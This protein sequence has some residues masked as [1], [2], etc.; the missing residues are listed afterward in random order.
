[1]LENKCSDKFTSAAKNDLWAKIAKTVSDMHGVEIK[2]F[3]ASEKWRSHKGA[4]KLAASSERRQAMRT[5]NVSLVTD[6]KMDEEEAKTYATLKEDMDPIQFSHHSDGG[7]ISSP[8][9]NKKTKYNFSPPIVI[10]SAAVSVPSGADYTRNVRQEFREKE[11]KIR[12]DYMQKEHEMRVKFET[13][14]HDERMKAL[15][16]VCKKCGESLHEIEQ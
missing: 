13:E 2:P 15:K 6:K 8:P 10:P 9:P 11:H 7:V 3:Q 16:N 12:L 14:F 1:M 5:G 4:M